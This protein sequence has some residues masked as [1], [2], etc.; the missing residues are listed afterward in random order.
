M[1]ER[2][3]G[4]SA[5]ARAAPPLAPPSLPNATAAG[6]LPA[7]LSSS[8]DPSHCSPMACST[9]RMAVLVKS[10]SLLERV[11]MIRLYAMSESI[12]VL[13]AK[14]QMD[15]LLKEYDTLRV[16]VLNRLNNS[17]QIGAIGITA[18]TWIASQ[19]NSTRPSLLII[20]LLVVVFLSSAITLW[21]DLY[22]VARH[23]AD[24]E[25]EINRLAGVTLLTWESYLS[26]G[27][28]GPFGWVTGWFGRRRDS[29]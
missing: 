15:V 1:A 23:I 29:N 11:G 3:F 27:S 8:G 17:F 14:E 6:F 25:R 12:Q 10:W 22:F 9:T 2:R 20:I 19:P 24:I 26:P 7:S 4:D 16:E 28:R 18:G 21:R 5:A 13:S